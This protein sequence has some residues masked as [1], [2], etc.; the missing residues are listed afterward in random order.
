ME[1][2][3][4]RKDFRRKLDFKSKVEK[5]RKIRAREEDYKREKVSENRGKKEEKRNQ[6]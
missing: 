1:E 2:K 5:L 6:K 3:V 4:V